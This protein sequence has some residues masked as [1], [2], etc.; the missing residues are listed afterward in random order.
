M[1]KNYANG[2]QVLIHQREWSKNK[3]DDRLEVLP[4]Q[5]TASRNAA[6][7][8]IIKRNSRQRLP[9]RELTTPFLWNLDHLY[10]YRTSRLKVGDSPRQ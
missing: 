5:R 7:S 2:L 8:L 4:T 9:L 3:D 6:T 1:S 10:Y